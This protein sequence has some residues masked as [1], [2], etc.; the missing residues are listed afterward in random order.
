MLR[1]AVDTLGPHAAVNTIGGNWLESG[2]RSAMGSDDEVER[3]VRLDDMG[4]RLVFKPEW[5]D[6]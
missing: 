3:S 4:I 6:G 5:S 1:L 2:P